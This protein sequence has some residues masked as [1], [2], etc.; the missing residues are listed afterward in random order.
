[1]KKIGILCVLYVFPTVAI[2]AQ[3]GDTALLKGISY[4]I[5]NNFYII[6]YAIGNFI[7]KEETSIIIFCDAV[8]N[9]NASKTVQKT[10]LYEVHNE[11]PKLWGELKINCCYYNYE[12]NMDSFYKSL[13]ME[14]D[15]S[16]LGK[17]YRFGWVGDFNENGITELMFAQSAY[18]EEGA[19]LEFWEFHNGAFK[20]TLPAQDDI[21]FIL[22]VNKKMHSMKL[23]RSKYSAVIDNYETRISEIFWDSKKFQYSVKE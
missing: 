9:K 12:E 4:S 3:N 8:K 18:S 17:P 22:D 10:F 16:A 5:P 15:L 2:Y 21:C 6:D 23:E 7:S 1:M 13:K 14:Q 20:I 11:K 19:T